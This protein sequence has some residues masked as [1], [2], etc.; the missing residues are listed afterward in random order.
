MGTFLSHG[1]RPRSGR[2]RVSPAA[3]T[4]RPARRKRLRVKGAEGERSGPLTLRPPCYQRGRAAAAER[5]RAEAS[6]ASVGLDAP[7]RSEDHRRSRS[8]VV[9]GGLL[10]TP[11]RN[12]TSETLSQPPGRPQSRLNRS[13]QGQALSISHRRESR[14]YALPQ[15]WSKGRGR[16]RGLAD[17]EAVRPL[18]AVY[19]GTSRA[20][21]VG[22][23]SCQR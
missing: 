15:F 8:T 2:R 3:G 5:G 4:R 7:S 17:M 21:G 19:P 1:E 9:P 13:K 14:A 20:E 12:T 16:G 6:A 11:D 22:F 23:L 18:T 10:S